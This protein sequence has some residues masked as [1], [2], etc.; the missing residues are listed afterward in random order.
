MQWKDKGGKR[1]AASQA[2]ED[3]V[4]TGFLLDDRGTPGEGRR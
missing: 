2:F 4:G 3:A 1:R